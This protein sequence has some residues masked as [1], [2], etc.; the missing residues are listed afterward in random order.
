MGRVGPGRGSDGLL[1]VL[2]ADAER[3]DS[4][5][6]EGH[7][8]ALAELGQR[9]REANRFR[10]VVSNANTAE[11]VVKRVADGIAKLHCGHPTREQHHDVNGRR[12]DEG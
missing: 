9:Q 5:L 4:Q 12:N 1:D 11:T 2:R 8:A 10:D 6:S 3:L 7:G